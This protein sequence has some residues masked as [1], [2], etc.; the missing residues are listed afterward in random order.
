M[1][2]LLYADAIR[3]NNAISVL[4]PTVGE[5]IDNEDDYY[6]AACTIIA[7]PYEMMVQLDDAKIDFTTITEFDLFRLL[8][9]KL[10]TLDTSKIFDGLDFNDFDV[11]VREG[12]REAI[13]I[14]K[15]TGI[16]IDRATHA[17][18]T[19]SL[20]KILNLPKNDKTPGNEE[21]RRYLINRERKKQKRRSRKNKPKASQLER[22]IISLV[23]T[24]EFPYDFKSVRDISIYQFYESLKQVVHKVHY[25]NTMIGYYA[26]T[27]K[28]DSV[29]QNDRTWIQLS[30]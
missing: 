14:N 16:T 8:L 26:G 2:S 29:P 12:G 18:I 4:I 9:P 20:R 23:N 28:I 17:M 22:Y 6:D 21:A 13:L 5:I 19:A 1:S 27:V 10:K 3:I 30:N 11:G 7:T 24:A 15:K 25:D